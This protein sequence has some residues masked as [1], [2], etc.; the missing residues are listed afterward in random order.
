[1]APNSEDCR[2]DLIVAFYGDSDDAFEALRKR[3]KFILRIKGGKFPNLKKLFATDPG[4]FDGY[5]HIWVA[6]DDLIVD[7]QKINALFDIA[8]RHDFWI[9]QPAFD[10]AGRISWPLTQKKGTD[11]RL[12]NF[13][14]VT[15]PLFRADKLKEFIAVY[16][17]QLVGWGIDWW[18]C[19]H[20]DAQNKLRFA[21]ID[22]ISVV[23]PHDEHRNGKTR[24][25]TKLQSDEARQ[26]A[27]RSTA[28]RYGLAEYRLRTIA[29]ISEDHPCAKADAPPDDPIFDLLKSF[30]GRRF[31][32]IFDVGAHTG[33]RTLD[34]ARRFPDARVYAFEPAPTI[35]GELER[36]IK[37]FGNVSP[38]Q[39]ALAQASKPSRTILGIDGRSYRLLCNDTGGDA[40]LIDASSVDDFCRLHNINHIDYMKIDTDGF[41]LNVL[42]GA[43][44]FLSK[45]DFIQCV[46]SANTYNQYH[47]SYTDTYQFLSDHGFYLYKVYNQVSEWG[48]AVIPCCGASN[49]CS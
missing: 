6:D 29:V 17:G 9:C 8:T 26:S 42:R 37:S 18:F 24:E 35:Y 7:P 46:V 22:T 38:H 10:N 40:G 12:T 19:N 2:W 20:F 23:N 1:M 32:T 31:D 41:D 43:E 36:R 27:W 30:P 13:V 45:V 14:E 44:Q 15:C 25:I 48:E 4:L 28:Q 3:S 33:A 49:L 5:S 16:D 47:F 39:L 11:V 34:L 21:I